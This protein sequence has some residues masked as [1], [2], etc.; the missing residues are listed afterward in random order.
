MSLSGHHRRRA[1]EPL[2]RDGELDVDPGRPDPVRRDDA[3]D[4]HASILRPLDR[5]P[6]DGHPAH[7][8]RA[9]R[10][11]CST[12]PISPTIRGSRWRRPTPAETT[13][14]DL[15]VSRPGGIV[16]TKTPGGRA[17][18]ADVPDIGAHVYPLLQYLDAT[19]EWRTGVTARAR[20][21]TPTPC[22][23]R[24]RPRP[25]RC[26]TPRRPRMKLIARIFAETGIRDLFCAAARDH[27]QAR[28]ARRRRCG[29]ATSGSRS[30]RASGRPATT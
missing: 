9:A 14:D 27:P 5:R 3:G 26:S 22:R 8:D 11:P 13:L 1:G 24:S 21:S 4:R 17:G 29:C 7:Q 19:R 15:L 12:T 6:G 18:L 16:R 30:I 20:G 25:T 10:G 23:T 28:L 2:R